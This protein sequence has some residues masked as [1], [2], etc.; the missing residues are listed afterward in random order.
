[1]FAP[2]ISSPPKLL[3]VD[4]RE[5]NLLALTAV[6]K[7]EPYEL[8]EATSGHQALELAHLHDFAAILLD[9]QM[10]E[11]DGFE[12]ARFLRKIGRSK[13]TPIIFLT[14]IH[15]TEAKA[16]MG[17]NVGAI[18]YLF[19]P[20]DTGILK[21]KLAI[22]AELYKKNYEIQFQNKLL[23]E[24]ILKETENKFLKDQLKARDE[25][26]AMASHELKTPITPLNLQMQSFL[27]LL[28]SNT[29]RTVDEQILER[30]LV[31]AYNQ[32]E[33][34][35][36]TIDK[37]LDVSRFTSGQLEMNFS[38]VNLG[39]L[40]KKVVNSF[41]IQMKNMGCTC[42]FE[43]QDDIVG[44][45]DAF[46][47]E[48]V[49]INLISNAMKYGSGQPIEVRVRAQNGEA[50]LIV[51]DYGIGI[52]KEDQTR[53]FNRFERAASPTNYGGLDLGLYIS[54]E[55]IRYH[56]GEIRVESDLGRGATFT[57]TLP[58]AL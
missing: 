13:T 3:I 9:V 31:S 12:T 38:E 55:I 46:R 51:K 35:S 47:I 10:P 21:A 22:L 49:T 48:Q 14:A 18:D 8:Y 20:I 33:R 42:S 28:R 4:D 27:R 32:V 57:V 43:I 16:N 24:Q 23:H 58:R 7:E 26:L 34:L 44:Y 11:L 2:P 39:E 29:L 45:W 36:Q 37:L 6:L 5:E 15:Q 1:M 50:E 30:M 56:R 19:K 17:Y 54:S 52:A 25:F 41:A 53:I 40:V